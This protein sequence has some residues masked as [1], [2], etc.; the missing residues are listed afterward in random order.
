MGT[1]AV[2]AGLLL[3]AAVAA[4]NLGTSEDDAATSEAANTEARKPLLAPTWVK[5]WVEKDTTAPD[6]F[7]QMHELKCRYD[8][9]GG[10]QPIKPRWVV[11]EAHSPTGNAQFKD[12]HDSAGQDVVVANLRNDFFP[13][14]IYAHVSADFEAV[15]LERGGTLDARPV[16]ANIDEATLE[17]PLEIKQPFD[18]W[19]ITVI[20]KSSFFAL[21]LARRPLSLAPFVVG[22]STTATSDAF[23]SGTAIGRTEGSV[24][25]HYFIAPK[26]GALS[27]K[28]HGNVE[29]PNV[30]IDGPNIYVAGETEFRKATEEEASG[31]GPTPP[32]PETDAA[33]PEP[34]VS[35][36]ATVD[37]A[38]EASAP[39]DCGVPGK[40]CCGGSSGFG[41]TCDPG[42]FCPANQNMCEACGGPGQK[43]CGGYGG[44][45]SAGSYCPSNQNM[46]EACGGP[47]QKCCGG[48]G[49]TC[50]AGS[51]CPS[52]Q[53]MCEACGKVGQKC[54]GGYGGTCE[55]GG[56]CPSNQNVCVVN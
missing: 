54:C 23:A 48:Y 39:R 47:G 41:G 31:A 27:A 19:P 56:R 52:N 22:Q 35:D 10:K 44:T 24:S 7:F 46:C 29:V 53:N 36:A 3:C 43:C 55:S 2:T 18:L 37:V 45:C 1:R 30:Q 13:L 51:Y 12:L 9:P 16:I 40:K 42:S 32:P 38:P 8:E 28:Y 49:G 34:I 14:K 20:Q 50:G 21:Q 6:P 17:H 11:V 25:T 33:V 5:C 4:C 26:Q 15:G